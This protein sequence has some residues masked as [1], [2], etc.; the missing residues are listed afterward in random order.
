MIYLLLA[1]TTFAVYV[2]TSRHDF[3]DYDDPD[4]VTENRIVRTGL[5]QDS[6]IW[7]FTGHHEYNWHPLTSLTHL[8]DIELFGL[9][10][11]GHHMMNLF[12]HIVNTLLLFG[13]LKAM[14]HSIGKSAFVAAVFALHPLHV[15]SVAWVSERKDVFSTMF[16]LLTMACYYKYTKKPSVLWYLL[17]GVVFALGL[18]AK[19]M[20]V[21][22]PFVLLLLDYWPLERFT[23]DNT[24][25]RH[26]L[27]LVIEKIPLFI[28]TAASC[29]ITFWVEH[30]GGAVSDIEA[31]PLDIR[32]ANAVIAYV[33][34]LGKIFVPINLAPFYPLLF[35][36]VTLAKVILSGAVLLVVTAAVIVPIRKYKYP[37]VGWFWYL[38]TLIPVIGL[39][40]VGSQSM[41]DRYVYVP[42]IGFSIAFTWGVSDLAAKL[43]LKKAAVITVSVIILAVLSL[44]TFRQV[45]Y[46]KND[47]TLFSH[48]AQVTEDNYLAH[49][50]LGNE[51]AD[52]EK[53]N[54]AAVHFDKALQIKPRYLEALNNIGF[55]LVRRGDAE[56]AIPFL[57]AALEID[58]NDTKANYNL[59]N[60]LQ[61]LGR[62]EESIS[63]YEKAVQFN[64]YFAEGRNNF[65]Y[66]LFL[67]DRY[68][69][70]HKQYVSSIELKPD[71]ETAHYNLANLCQARG[72]LDKAMIHYQ[73]AIDLK[74][75][76]VAAHY[77]L[78]IVYLKQNEV[79]PAVTH[80][81]EALKINP[82]F[83]PAQKAL[84]H[85]RNSSSMNQF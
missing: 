19:P 31:I 59:A 40:Q 54:E 55:A 69:E 65:G 9:N 83:T 80:L 4:Y 73:I 13:I 63:H 6:I 36:S 12:Y 74:P 77:N 3:I 21:T 58:P 18:M 47:M 26:I 71:Y 43:K 25:R 61:Y 39:V 32:L 75:D 51:L 60:A 79:D 49:A 27:K 57:E 41:A 62:T 48:T 24:Q 1:V 16:W 22:L 44:L 70:A 56:D 14:T 84:N 46:W 10:P 82:E 64:P 42:L 68:D 8:L 7:A 15:E 23:F 76:Y 20:L 5:N 29:V 52:E 2:Q 34:Y 78:A 72:Q 38:G 50:I 85:L 45:G 30:R 67:L 17:T 28:L 37:A 11:A 66:A 81:R 53:Y 33:A 35:S